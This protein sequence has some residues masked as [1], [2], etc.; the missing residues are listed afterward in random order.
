MQRYQASSPCGTSSEPLANP[1]LVGL[2]DSA[3]V[4]QAAGLGLLDE[5]RQELL[6]LHRVKVAV[7]A[8]LAPAKIED[9]VAFFDPARMDDMHARWQSTSAGTE[10]RVKAHLL[11]P[12]VTRLT[13]EFNP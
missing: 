3:H 11:A 5:G 4:E 9:G 10:R 1:L 6:L 7:V 13:P 2:L 12:P 8:A